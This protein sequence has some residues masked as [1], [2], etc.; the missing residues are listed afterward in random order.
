MNYSAAVIPVTKADKK[1]DVV[2]HAYQPIDENDRTNWVA[3]KRSQ[4][5]TVVFIGFSQQLIHCR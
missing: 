2:D 5:G 4:S 1:I 3:C